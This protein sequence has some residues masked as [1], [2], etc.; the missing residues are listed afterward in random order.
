MYHSLLKINVGSNPDRP[1]PGREWL[2]NLYRVH[3]RLCMAF[4]SDDQKCDDPY[5]IKPFIPEEFCKEF[6]EKKYYERLKKE[7]IHT[8]RNRHKGFLFR[9]DPFPENQVVIFVL[10]GDSIVPNWD[11]AFQNA[12]YLLAGEPIVTKGRK[13]YSKGEKYRF[14]L[15]ANA[16]KRNSVKTANNKPG[17][18]IPV[19]Y[20]QLKNW[21]KRKSEFC[22]FSFLSE[23]VNVN[24]GYVRFR[25]KPKSGENNSN[26]WNRLF[27]AQ[28]EGHLTIEDENL[29]IQAL[30]SGIGPAKAFGFGLLSLAPA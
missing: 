25:K 3:Q 9:I 28:F 22:G 20:D 26:G 24:P 19:E 29:F 18:R 1:R 23:E 30:E 2:K 8:V 12:S 5:F 21:L 13:D 7:F 10:S 6:K 27:S 17:N 11:Y 16:T 14:R 4:P 15:K